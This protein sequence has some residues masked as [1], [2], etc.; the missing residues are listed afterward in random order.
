MY[1]DND[2]WRQLFSRDFDVDLS[3]LKLKPD[4]G[5]WREAYLLLQEQHQEARHSDGEITKHENDFGE[6]HGMVLDYDGEPVRFEEY[7][8]VSYIPNIMHKHNPRVVPA[9][10]PLLQK[11]KSLTMQNYDLYSSYYQHGAEFYVDLHLT[12]SLNM[13]PRSELIESQF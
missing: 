4:N 12:W 7:L 13:S 10:A 9:L 2:V 5:T 11:A 8:Y 6:E 3:A 1:K